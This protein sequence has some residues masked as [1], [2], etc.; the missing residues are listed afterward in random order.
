M[1]LENEVFAQD[2]EHIA[3][4]SFLPWE[5]LEGKR[6]LVTGATGLI[7]HALTCVLLYRGVSV[8]A[9]V[10]DRKRAEE[11][12]HA[13]LEAGCPLSFL[14]GEVETTGVVDGEINYIVHC[15]APTASGY[16][17]QHPVETIRSI[18]D[19]TRN[20]LELAREKNC[21]GMV[22]LSSMEVYGQVLE[23]KPLREDC[24]GTLDLSSPRTS[25][26]EAKRLAEN[27]CVCYAAEYSVPVRTLR[28]AQ[29]FGPGV[30]REDGRVFAYIAR[31]GLDGQ[32]VALATDGSKENMY[33][34]TA[35]AVSAIIAVLLEGK[36]GGI[37]NAANEETYTSVRDMARIGLDALGRQDLAVELN[38]GSQLAG[39]Y[40]PQ[41]YLYLDATALRQLGWRPQVGLADMY[42]RMAAGFEQER[43]R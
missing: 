22:F 24:L 5:R 9:L 1:W 6:V 32:N 37:Y 36:D 31:C 15:A 8:L 3:R 21:A 18:V 4:A 38:V 10:R 34:Y 42:V 33:L 11:K 29:T 13:Q 40:R 39:G 35:D 16:F 26:P 30:D 25:Y 14:E 7:G 43:G 41:G 19:G 2:L 23:K 28:L 12:F 20:M 27:L 17:V